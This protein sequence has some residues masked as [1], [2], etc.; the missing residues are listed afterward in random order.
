M[1]NAISSIL[2]YVQFSTNAVLL[3][4]SIRVFPSQK[5]WLDSTVWP[6]LRAQDAAYRS[7]DR[8]AYKKAQEELE[9]GI[10]LAKYRQI[11]T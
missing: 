11:Q 6:L 7:G 9:M 8:L 1:V 2:S 10:K 3:T 5:R 4:K